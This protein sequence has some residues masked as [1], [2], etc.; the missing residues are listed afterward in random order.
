MLIS[1]VEPNVHQLIQFIYFLQHMSMSL[2]SSVHGSSIPI[3]VHQSS[4]C[5]FKL[6]RHQSVNPAKNSIVLA[7]LPRITSICWSVNPYLYSIKH[8][9]TKE[10]KKCKSSIEIISTAILNIGEPC[11]QQ[12]ISS[13][14]PLHK[15]CTKGALIHLR[16]PFHQLSFV[17]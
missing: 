12:A 7:L 1:I 3:M 17:K 15:F 11:I 4:I 2:L 6:T 9:Q 13:I 8:D 14:N 16:S 5:P 10:D